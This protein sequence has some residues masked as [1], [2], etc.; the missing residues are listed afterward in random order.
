MISLTTR[1]DNARHSVDTLRVRPTCLILVPIMLQ[2]E[3][4]FLIPLR[5]AWKF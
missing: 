1:R 5:S 4:L 3:E 2:G